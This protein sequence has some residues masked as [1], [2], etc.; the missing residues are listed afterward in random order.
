MNRAEKISSWLGMRRDGKVRDVFI[1][2]PRTGGGALMSVLKD[3][4]EHLPASYVRAYIHA[5][6]YDK[7]F[8][9]SIAR[10][11]WDRL[12]S[13]YMF[14]LQQ[15]SIRK[16][17]P[18]VHIPDWRKSTHFVNVSFEDFILHAERYNWTVSQLYW[19]AEH[20][21]IDLSQDIIELSPPFKYTSW[22]PEDRYGKILIKRIL[23]FEK[24]AEDT[25]QLCKQRGGRVRAPGDLKDRARRGKDVMRQ[26]S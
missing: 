14:F 15:G 20:D 25:K 5:S 7:Y 26:S 22:S 19:L 23:R 11:T 21:L 17:T 1:H 10:N 2:V 24:L 6:R 8:S 13:V 18:F 4:T 16:M 12:L 9:F 3:A